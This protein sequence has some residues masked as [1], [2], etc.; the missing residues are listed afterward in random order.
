MEASDYLGATEIGP[1]YNAIYN[2]AWEN[3][4]DY[5]YSLNNLP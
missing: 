1:Y 3:W 4:W 2:E 5:G